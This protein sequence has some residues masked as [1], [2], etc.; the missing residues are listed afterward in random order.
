LKMVEA[1]ERKHEENMFSR[2]K[3]SN[4]REEMSEQPEFIEEIMADTIYDWVDSLRQWFSGVKSA[5]SK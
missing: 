3:R 5:G 2:R 4:D 1:A